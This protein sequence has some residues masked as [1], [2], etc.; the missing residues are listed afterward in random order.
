[1]TANCLLASAESALPLQVEPVPLIET[2]T[3]IPMPDFIGTLS[4]SAHPHAQTGPLQTPKN[5]RNQNDV[6]HPPNSPREAT[7]RRY[8]VGSPGRP[9]IG[10]P[11]RY[12][13]DAKKR[14]MCQTVLVKA[15]RLRL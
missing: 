15:A 12:P 5:P 2:G 11:S 6:A 4:A 8:Q 7:R 9:T 3:L 14:S 1:M 10:S 13:R